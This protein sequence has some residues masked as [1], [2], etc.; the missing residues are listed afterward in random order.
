[1]VLGGCATA[2]PVM[3]PDGTQHFTV[4]CRRS[5][6]CFEEAARACPNGYTLVSN[7]PGEAMLI[8]C[9]DGATASR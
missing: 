6:G 7:N 4:T 9:R 5:A 2:S 8:K 1:M 3:G